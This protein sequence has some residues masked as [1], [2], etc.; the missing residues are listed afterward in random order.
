MSVRQ[1]H[2]TIA[3]AELAVSI[4]QGKG[5]VEQALQNPMQRKTTV[6][7]TGTGTAANIGNEAPHFSHM[8]MCEPSWIGGVAINPP[9]GWVLSDR[10]RSKFEN[11]LEDCGNKQ[12]L[13]ALEEA[14]G[15]SVS[16][17]SGATTN[18]MGVPPALP[19]WQ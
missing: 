18:V 6:D 16:A 4:C 2:G 12:E 8:A 11:I 14:L 10:T 5:K 17:S 19:G 3:A 13:M 1:A 7:V 15:L 9:L